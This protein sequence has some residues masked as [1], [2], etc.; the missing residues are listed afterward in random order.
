[1]FSFLFRS[2]FDASYLS[3]AFEE[4]NGSEF[5]IL[6]QS[7]LRQRHY[8]SSSQA[9][10]NLI[11]SMFNVG[12]IAL[13]AAVKEIGIPLYIIGIGLISIFSTYS[14]KMLIS[15]AHEHDIRNLDDLCDKIFGNFGF[16]TSSI[17]QT[18][19]SIFLICLTFIVWMD[20]FTDIFYDIIQYSFSNFDLRA[21]V[22]I[23]GA[24][25]IL[26]ICFYTRS[27]VSINLLSCATVAAGIGALVSLSAALCTSKEFSRLSSGDHAVQAMYP[28]KNW[29]IATIV[30]TICY[31]YIQVCFI[32]VL[33]TPHGFIF[34]YLFVCYDLFDRN[35][36]LFMVV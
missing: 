30:I 29:W 13:P 6:V 10:F 2:P 25:I 18:I 33:Y 9:L 27:M 16:Y 17:L 3:L 5:E 24:I 22:L 35:L 1:M 14:S 28:S 20:V 12:I 36:L 4:E 32:N 34:T 31:S 8:S 15:I 21:I 19:V 26:P 11:Y 7:Y 23:G